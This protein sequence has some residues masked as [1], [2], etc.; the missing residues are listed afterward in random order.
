MPTIRSK[1][2]WM[3]VTSGGRC[4]AGTLSQPMTRVCGLNPTRIESNAG[5]EA[6]K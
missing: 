5:M 6:P 4:D 3:S 2:R 1:L